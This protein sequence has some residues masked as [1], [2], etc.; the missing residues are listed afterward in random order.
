MNAA[1]THQF[2]GGR[3]SRGYDWRWKITRDERYDPFEDVFY[4]DEGIIK[5]TDQKPV[6]R[7]KIR[8]Y[9]MSRSEDDL[10]T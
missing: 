4:D 5:L 6:L 3:Q 9:F 2:H 8:A 1:L 7:D 10:R